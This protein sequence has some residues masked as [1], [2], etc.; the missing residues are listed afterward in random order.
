MKTEIMRREEAWGTGNVE[1][2]KTQPGSGWDKPGKWQR[3]RI[4]ANGENED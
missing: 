2:R 3:M 4:W 1:G